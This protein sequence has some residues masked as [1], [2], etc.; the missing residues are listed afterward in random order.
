MFSQENRPI[1]ITTKL[2]ETALL[3]FHF[4]GK[5]SVSTPFEFQVTMLSEDPKVD[6]KSLLGTGATITV[7]LAD[8][9][10][11]YFH[12]LFSQLSQAGQNESKL[13]TYEGTIVP[14]LWFLNLTTDCRIFQELSAKAII[15][16]ILKENKVTDYRFSLSADPPKREYCVQ[17]RESDFNFVS[18]LL[19]EEGIFYF[20]EHAN[21]KHT[22]VMAD[23]PSVFPTCPNQASASMSFSFEGWDDNDGIFSFDRRES[24]YTRKVTLT[25]YDFQ[26]PSTDLRVNVGTEVEHYD[27]PGGYFERGEGTRRSNILLDQAE[28]PRLTFSGS[29]RCRAFTSGYK[30]TLKDHYRSDMNNK[31]YVLLSVEHEAKDNNYF[32]GAIFDQPFV[33][34]NNFEAIP[35]DAKYRPPHRAAKPVIQ[36]LQSALVVGKAGEEIWV[37]KFGRVKVHFFWDRES[38]KNEN[39]SCWVRVSQAWAGKN[40]GF[41]TIPR[42]GQEVLVEFLEGDP[43]RPLI[44]GR[45]YN[46]E[47]MPPYALPADQTQSGIKSRSS[48]GG[49][50]SNFN[51]IRLEDKKGSELFS[52]QAEKDMETLV[53][54]DQS[55]T[56][57]NDKTIK[58]EGKHTETITKDTSITIEQG[59]ETHT[60]KQ[61]NQT[62]TLDMGNRSSKIKM[63]NDSIN[64]DL[65]KST[66]EAMQSIELKVGSSSIKID[67]M[68][69]T[70]KGMMIKIE[71]TA[72]LEAKSPM[73]QVKGDG[74]L[75]LKGGLTMIN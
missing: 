7:T 12:G 44:T 69:V 50:T 61:G 45:V 75:I 42:I 31:S 68:G 56:V 43:D 60:L 8:G 11:H 2:G 10:K 21:G 47:Q 65:G 55:T 52:V 28:V 48:K 51:E 24:V 62:I 63:G 34:T 26:K 19:E 14:S 40:W 37:D 22:L 53:K 5:E 23:K 46:A 35:S 36:G 49:G 58:V 4:T 29:S 17:Y 25:D 70:I 27:H 9:K 39:S 73:S 59:N 3:L 6:L 16:K 67:Q 15:E 57:K 74:L 41:V 64:I 1:R 33:Y 72:M 71:G 18:R 32:A 30:F 54:N 13:V 38:Q 20:F 66:T